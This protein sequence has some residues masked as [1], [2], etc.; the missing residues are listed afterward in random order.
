MAELVGAFGVPHTPV[1]PWFVK[2]DGPHCETAQLFAALTENLEALRARPD[3][4]VRHR[5]SQHVLPRQPADLRGRRDRAFQGPERRAARGARLHHQVAAGLRRPCAPARGR[6]GLRPGAGA[7]VHRRPFGRGAAALHDAADAAPGGADLHQRPCPAAAVGAALLRAR[8]RGQARDREPGRNRCGS[9]P[10]AAAA[11]RSTSGG[12]TSRPAAPTACP[13]PTGRSASASY[14]EQAQGPD[15]DRRV[16][17]GADA[18][19]RQCRRRAAQ[20]DRHARH[21]RRAQAAVRQAA[22]A[23]R[24]CLCRWRWS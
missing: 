7:G 20:L 5:S 23:E 6:R 21:H 12:R 14:L 2:R 4:D 9:S 1:F 16:D 10:W 13:T 19:G 8:P 17:R 11:S 18:Q 3:R 24:P 22:D 15:P